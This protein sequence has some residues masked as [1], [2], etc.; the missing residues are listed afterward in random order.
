MIGFYRKLIFKI[1]GRKKHIYRWNR[2]YVITMAVWF[3]IWFNIKVG[4]KEIAFGFH[5]PY[6]YI[7]I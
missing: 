1:S 7:Y 5:K 2:L 6:I 4:H 3:E